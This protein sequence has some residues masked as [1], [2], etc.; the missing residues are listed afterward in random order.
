MSATGFLNNL[1]NGTPPPAVTTPIVSQSGLPDWYQQYLAGIAAQGTNVAQNAS[2]TGQE[3]TVA[4]LADQTNQA[5]AQTQA[6]QGSQQPGMAQAQGYTNTIMPTATAAS[7]NANALATPSTGTFTGSNVQNYMSPYTQSVVNGLVNTSNLNLFN[8]IIPNL[9][10]SFIGSGQ[11]GSTR[12]ADVLMQG[13]NQNQTA[14]NAQVAQ[15]LQQGY[16]NAGQQ[17]TADQG[18]KIAGQTL[19]AQTA[20]NA[21]QLDTTA[22]QAA[23]Q[24]TGALTQMNNTMQLQNTGALSAAGQTIQNQNQ[25][26]A[27]ANQ[28]N[29]VAASNFPWQQLNNLS[30]LVRG[31]QLPTTTTSV[32]AGPAPNYTPS[33]LAQAT[34]ALGLTAGGNTTP[35]IA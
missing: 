26:V 23:G 14:L 8:N 5:I 10:S 20:L 25:A 35:T 9:N 4:P 27:N 19:G 32:S 29:A 30:G 13:I 11:F 34:Q 22:A 12:N 6:L 33:P 24:Q 18:Q 28:A 17:F 15:T 16:Q 7:A 1:Y 21:G 3:A 2:F 31:Q